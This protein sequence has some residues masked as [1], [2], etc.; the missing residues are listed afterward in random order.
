M[1]EY[2]YIFF[3]S[4]FDIN[5]IYLN[6]NLYISFIFSRYPYYNISKYEFACVFIDL[7]KC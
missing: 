3:S 7:V 1:F 5:I 6:T 2:K 4:L